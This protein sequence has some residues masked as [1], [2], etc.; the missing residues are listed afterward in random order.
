MSET[1]GIDLPVIGCVGTGVPGLDV[2]LA[3]LSALAV[4]SFGLSMKLL[5]GETWR[6]RIGLWL[7]DARV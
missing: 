6:V 7:L 3:T 4:F 5:G 2:F 1:C